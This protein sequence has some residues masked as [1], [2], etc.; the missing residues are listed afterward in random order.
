MLVFMPEGVFRRGFRLVLWGCVLVVAW[1]AFAPFAEPA[2]FTWDKAN[3]VLAFFVMAAL[4]DGGYPGRNRE[5][6]RWGLLLGY[7]LVIELVQWQL[8]Y[9]ELSWLDLVAN[10]VGVLLYVGLRAWVGWRIRRPY[11]AVRSRS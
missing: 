7:G 2:G 9:R 10:V 3:H 11:G 8:P 5:L 1:L 4:A 6:P